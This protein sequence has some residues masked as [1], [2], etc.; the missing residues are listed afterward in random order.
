MDG[1]NRR[2][3]V[4]THTH[5]IS[6]LAVDIAAKRLYFVDPKTDRVE[7][8]DYAGVDRQTV[9]SGMINAPHPFGLTLFDQYLYWTDWTRLGKQRSFVLVGVQAVEFF[10]LLANKKCNSPTK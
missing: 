8:I 5:Q 6:G 2:V 4:E 10:C 7:S 1:T 3:L 9:V